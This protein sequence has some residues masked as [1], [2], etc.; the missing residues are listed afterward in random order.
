M[1]PLKPGLCV[2]SWKS[3]RFPFLPH[4]IDLEMVSIAVLPLSFFQTD[5]FFIFLYCFET[6]T[7][8]L[9]YRSG[10]NGGVLHVEYGEY[11]SKKG[12]INAILLELRIR[13]DADSRAVA[14]NASRN[15]PSQGR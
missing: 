8:L 6:A 5:G 11:L 7:R 1:D 4:C 10:T 13:R 3:D 15:S 12:H 9:G 14:R 2:K